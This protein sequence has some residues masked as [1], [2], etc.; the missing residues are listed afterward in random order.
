MARYYSLKA[1]DPGGKR[2]LLSCQIPTLPIMIASYLHLGR[3]C[4]PLTGS[5]KDLLHLDKFLVETEGGVG[6][7][8]G[9]L[10]HPCL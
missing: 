4:P 6:E 7:V 2:F 9:G 5:F 1:S 8:G 10:T 3:A